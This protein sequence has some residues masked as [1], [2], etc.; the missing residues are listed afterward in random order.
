MLRQ[1]EMASNALSGILPGFIE[2]FA[3]LQ[4]LDLSNQT[5]GF[6]GPI[7]ENLW[8]HL[9]LKT[10]HLA[11]S[12]LTGTISSLVG[13]LAVLEVFDMTNNLLKGSLPSEL[14]LLGGGGEYTAWY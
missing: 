10:L 12:R 8:R 4:E 6:K 11:G 2:S 5:K 13:N 1:F 14:G 9:S 7:P 3:T